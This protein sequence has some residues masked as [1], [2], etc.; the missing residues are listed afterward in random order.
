MPE[1][2]RAAVI[3]LDGDRVCLIRR[4]RGG[5]TYF[6]FPGG[7]VEQASQIFNS[8]KGKP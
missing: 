5:D 1:R 7:G 4:M 6:L 2:I 3:L 8:S